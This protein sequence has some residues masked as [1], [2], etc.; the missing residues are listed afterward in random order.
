[1][2]KLSFG[3]NS[4]QLPNGKLI[5]CI[6]SST[7]IEE[8]KSQYKATPT[9]LIT[10][11][12]FDFNNPEKQTLDNLTCSLIDQLAWQTPEALAC[13]QSLYSRCRFGKQ[14]P[15]DT[16]ELTLRQMLDG[17]EETFIVIDALDEC[18]ERGEL[19]VLLENL[20]LGALKKLHILITSRKLPDIKQTLGYL[21]TCEI[22]LQKASVDNDIHTLLSERLQNDS[23]LKL[24]PTNVRRE[25]E[26]TLMHKAQGMYATHF[27]YLMFFKR[28]TIFKV[29][30][31]C[32]PTRSA[33]E[34]HLSKRCTES[35]KVYTGNPG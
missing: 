4:T 31:G 20:Y 19:L 30:M 34:M 33:A 8:V 13:L 25:I 15:Q 27:S 23:R 10:Y 24:L 11:F 3:N 21:V 26:E 7:V 35:T 5:D 9:V 16:F 17:V 2:G 29:S 32:M 1:L 22:Y 28:L 14:Q 18:K 12:Y 6:R